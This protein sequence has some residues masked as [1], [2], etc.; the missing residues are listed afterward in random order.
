MKTFKVKLGFKVHYEVEID[1]DA[2]SPIAA[3]DKA[4]EAQKNNALPPFKDVHATKP[5]V[6]SVSDSA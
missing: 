3:L 4:V 5:A 6:I 1:I 2:E